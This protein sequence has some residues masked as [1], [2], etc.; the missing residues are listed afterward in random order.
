MV[1]KNSQLKAVSVL[2]AGQDTASNGG[3]TKNFE[4]SSHISY[5]TAVNSYDEALA[6]MRKE[7]FDVVVLDTEQTDILEAFLNSDTPGKPRIIVLSASR[8]QDRIIHA[9]EKG[10]HGYVLKNNYLPDLMKALEMAAGGNFY[11]SPDVASTLLNAI[12]SKESRHDHDNLLTEQ[13]KRVLYHVCR[14]QGNREIARALH[15]SE[16]TVMR[17]KQNIKEK[18]GAKNLVGYLAYALRNNIVQLRDL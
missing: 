16:F 17:H 1:I 2:L 14:Q 4:S 18:I 11:Y 5:F 12:A 15:L 3:F 10:V 6:L 8:D 9:Y 7:N 13:E